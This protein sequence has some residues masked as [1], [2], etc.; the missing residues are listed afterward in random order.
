MSAYYSESS[1]IGVVRTGSCS[2]LCIRT[3]SSLQIGIATRS[4]APFVSSPFSTARPTRGATTSVFQNAKFPSHQ[5]RF[6]A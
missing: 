5:D 2:D 1:I 4:L 3:V 6:G